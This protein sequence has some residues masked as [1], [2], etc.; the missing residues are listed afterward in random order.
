MSAWRRTHGWFHFNHGFFNRSTLRQNGEI[1]NPCNLFRFESV[2]H[3][4]GNSTAVFTINLLSRAN[5]SVPVER[6]IADNYLPSAH[7]A[8]MFLFLVV[9][10][11]S[12]K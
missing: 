11:H 10:D 8:I 12:E 7:N 4:Y 3:F 9:W 1:L 2:D 6:F 5:A